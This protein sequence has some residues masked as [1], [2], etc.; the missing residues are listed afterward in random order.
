MRFLRERYAFCSDITACYERAENA[1]AV[2]TQIFADAFY[3][4]SRRPL[5]ATAKFEKDGG[6]EI[7]KDEILPARCGSNKIETRSASS[8]VKQPVGEPTCR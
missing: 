5:Y 8:N 3:S 2:R 4:S 6:G 1:Y 7:V